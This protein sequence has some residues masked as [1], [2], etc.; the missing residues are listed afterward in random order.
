MSKLL[1]LA[2]GA[3]LGF[4]VSAPLYAADTLK[5]TDAWTDVQVQN[6]LDK[7]HAMPQPDQAKCVTNIRPVASRSTDPSDDT[8]VKS[9]QYSEE[10]YLAATKKCDAPSVKNRDRCIANVKDHFGRM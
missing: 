1:N 5:T 8:N 10:E 7:C 6:A 3:A 2:L 4:A 9:G